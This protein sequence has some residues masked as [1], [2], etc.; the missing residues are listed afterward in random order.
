MFNA[1]IEVI[2]DQLQTKF[3]N[4]CVEAVQRYGFKIDKD[5]LQKAL[6][7]SKSFYDEGYADAK[8]DC[9]FVH[10]TI[11]N[12]PR[13]RGCDA[14]LDKSRQL[15]FIDSMPTETAKRLGWTWKEDSTNE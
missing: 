10:V 12:H 5:R 15:L 14:W 4:D 6:T 7:E 3:E 11:I 13:Y 8:K 1:G 2:Y 9:N